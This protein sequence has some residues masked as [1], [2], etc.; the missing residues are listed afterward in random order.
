MVKHRSC[1]TMYSLYRVHGD[2]EHRF[3]GWA[4]KPRSDG[5]PVWASKPAAPVWWF[6]SQNHRDSFLVWTSKSNRLQF[7]GCATKPTEEGWCGTRVEIWL[8]A[9]R[10]SMSR[11]GF[12]SLASRLVETQRWVVHIASLRRLRR[13][14][15]EDGWVDTTDCVGP[16]YAKNV[17]S[18]VLGHRDI[19]VF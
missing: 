1:D 5:F 14:E 17:I 18:S 15:A 4:P 7:V 11:Y 2:E 9:S 3:L 13:V 8:F 10:E 12:F 6:G 16:S 19:I